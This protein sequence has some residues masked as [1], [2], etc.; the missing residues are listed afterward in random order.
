MFSFKSIRFIIRLVNLT[1]SAL[2]YVYICF[3]TAIFFLP[4]VAYQLALIHF[5]AHV[6]VNNYANDA[7]SHLTVMGGCYLRP[8]LPIK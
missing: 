2:Y 8:C 3:Q 7:L 5:L 1:V 6:I 4:P